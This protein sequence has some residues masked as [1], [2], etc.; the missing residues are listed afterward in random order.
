MAG[1]EPAPSCVTG[2]CEKPLH[3]TRQKQNY[4]AKGNRRWVKRVNIG[5]L[6]AALFNAFLV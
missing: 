5:I 1:I 6:A 3:R 2:K 4:Y